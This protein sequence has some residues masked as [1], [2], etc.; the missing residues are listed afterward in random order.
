MANKMPRGHAATKAL[1]KSCAEFQ[2]RIEGLEDAPS[3]RFIPHDNPL[4]P[5]NGRTDGPPSGRGSFSPK[6]KPKG[7]TTW[8]PTTLSL[9]PNY[10]VPMAGDDPALT[11]ARAR[12]AQGF[13]ELLREWLE[14]NRTAQPELS[15]AA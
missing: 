6:A 5:Y 13:P 7:I 3:F 12:W 9:A 8:T 15:L 10:Q 1:I 4:D 14:A 11:H 2:V